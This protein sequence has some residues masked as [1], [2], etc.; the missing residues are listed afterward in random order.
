LIT[1]CSSG[2]EEQLVRDA[3]KD[4]IG[5]GALDANLLTSYSKKNVFLFFSFFLKKKFKKKKT[6]H[7]AIFHHNAYAVNGDCSR[8]LKLGEAQYQ[9]L[10][11]QDPQE[12]RNVFF[13]KKYSDWV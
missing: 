9:A 11:K 7:A 6:N 4:N 5:H 13:S 2:S 10:P 12:M 1:S 8:V 3:Y